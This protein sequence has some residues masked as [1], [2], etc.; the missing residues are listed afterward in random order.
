MKESKNN[1]GQQFHQ[2]QHYTLTYWTPY[3]NP[4]P[5]LGQA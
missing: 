4:G 1:D 2:Y 3:I 5:D